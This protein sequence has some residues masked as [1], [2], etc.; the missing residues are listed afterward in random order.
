MAWSRLNLDFYQWHLYSWMEEKE[1]YRSQAPYRKQC[2]PVVLGEIPMGPLMESSEG[3]ASGS[4]S[5]AFSKMI[6]EMQANGWAGA[7]VWSYQGRVPRGASLD[8]LVP[9]FRSVASA[10]K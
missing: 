2:A 9:A 10:K 4:L 7:W 1:I 5:E 6:Q 3:G 8:I